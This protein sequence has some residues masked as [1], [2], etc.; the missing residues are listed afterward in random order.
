MKLSLDKPNNRLW[1]FFFIL[2]L[3]VGWQIYVSQGKPVKIDYSAF[4]NQLEAGKVERITVQGDKITGSLKEKAKKRVGENQYEE[5]KEFVTY[6]PSFGDPDLMNQLKKHR[7]EVRTIP[8][9]NYHIWSIVLMTLP[10]L[11]IL[12]IGYVQY[13]RM[14]GGQ[15]GGI[16]SIG[17]SQARRYDHTREKTLF[18]DVAGSEST[19]I[20]LQEI[21]SFLKEPE[22][23]IKLGGEIPKG[24]MLVGPPGNGKTLL[25]RAVAGEADAPFFSITGSDFMEMFVGVGAKRVRSLFQD[26]KKNAPSIIFIDEIDAIGRRRGAGLGGGH[27]E[28]EQ[29]LNQLLSELDGFE[30]NENVIVMTATNRPDILD[31]A[32]TRPGRFDRRIIVDLPNVSERKE[33][34]EMYAKNKS[35]ASG[36]DLEELA[37]STP[38]FSGADLKNILNEAAILAVREE[39]NEI[40]D[41]IIEESRDK[42]FM[43]LIRKGLAL[44]DEEKKLIAYHEAGHAIVGALLPNADPIHKVS[45]IPRSQAMGMTQQF[46]EREIYIYKREYLLDR[47]TVMMGGRAAEAFIYNTATSGAGNDLQQA[48]KLARKMIIEWGMSGRF[49]HMALG[50]QEEHVF[51]GEELGKHREYS[52]KT[53]QEVDQEVE[54]L[55]DKSFKQASNM[56]KEKRQALDQL[57]EMLVAEEEVSGQSVYDLLN[58]ERKGGDRSE[59][60]E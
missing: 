11:F 51:L 19:K 24:V 44:T 4:L 3:F 25:A 26:A 41:K 5:Y 57:A 49:E 52:E 8:E 45:I 21:V 2:L 36:V 33:I 50:G 14:Q 46:P 7:V 10:F 22:R 55:L 28:R 47:M 16:F 17:K 48:T 58:I 30:P 54:S 13:R 29:T 38:G 15:G 12:W 39:K 43:G 20:E 40:D 42:I 18:K 59:S 23:I 6:T 27:D 1:L 53:A 60:L 9:A 37:R 31:P 34:L 56:I 35:F 32:L